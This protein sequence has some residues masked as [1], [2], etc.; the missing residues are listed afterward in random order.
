[1]AAAPGASNVAVTTSGGTSNAM[2]FTVTAVPGISSLS[3][4]TAT[5][6]T[7]VTISGSNL[8]DTQGSGTVW[9]G[10][11]PA[12]VV[13]WSNTQ[14][15]ATVAA[16]AQSGYAR[17]LQNGRWSQPVTF[18]VLTPTITGVTPNPAAPGNSVTIS[19]SGFG[20]LQGNGQVWLG[21]AAAATVTSWNDAQIVA[22]V[23]ANAQS[24][25]AQVLQNGVMSNAVDFTVNIP[26]ITGIDPVKGVA[27]ASVTFTGSGFGA[28]GSVTLGSMAGQVQSWSDTQVVAQ[29]ASGSVSG[30]A[31]IQR[32]DGLQSN[33]LGFTVP[34]A[35]GNTLMPSLLNMAVG[36][37]R[38]LQALGGGG[39]TVT[40]LAWST[41]DATV[42]SLSTDDPPLLTA[43]APGHVTIQAGSASAD[44][45]VWAGVLPV[46][47]ATWSNP[48]NDS[49]VA[50][51]IPA[52]PSATGVA[53]VFAFMNDGTVQ[54]ITSDGKVAWTALAPRG[55]GLLDFQGGLVVEQWDAAGPMITRL[56]GTT[57]VASPGYR[58]GSLSYSAVH[59]DG[60][61]ILLDQPSVVGVNL[62]TGEEKFRVTVETGNSPSYATLMDGLIIAGD[63]YAYVPYSWVEDTGYTPG[64]GCCIVTHFMILRVDSS[65]A[66]D[67]I[68]VKEYSTHGPWPV[69]VGADMITNADQGIVFI[70]QADTNPDDEVVRMPGPSPDG[71][72]PRSANRARGMQPRLMAD[73]E[74]GMGVTTGASVTSFASAP[75]G[76][77]GETITPVLQAQDGSFF[78]TS[79]MYVDGNYWSFMES[80]D[81]GGN[82]RWVVP[83]ETPQIATADG[84]V[85]GASGITY[86]ANGMATGSVGSLPTYS[87]IGNWYRDGDVQQIA[88]PPAA[89]AFSYAAVQG[90]NP[91]GNGAAVR[92]LSAPQLALYA[93]AAANLTATPQ[94]SALLTQFANIARIPEATLAAQLQATARG[95]RDFVFDGP[96]SNAPL[97]P[98]KFPGAASPGVT[99]V[100]EWFG[101][102]DV[103]PY[104]AEGFSQF[105]EYAVWFRLN[106]WQSWIKGW[107]SGFLITST[108]KVNYYAMGT[109]MHEVLHKQ[110]VGGGF[111]HNKPPDARDMGAAISAVGWPSGMVPDH[112]PLSEAFGLLCF[113]GLK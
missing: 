47:T 77:G 91:S 97:D 5:G 69:P 108:G 46:G 32:S 105:N 104:Y 70:Y 72:R 2:P 87:W 89:F 102:Y 75:M 111:T 62:S 71:R 40:G 21:T 52:V 15:A 78:G 98:A 107:F 83:N 22:T 29:V 67:K 50:N 73:M 37:T 64:G 53:D 80:F 106:D 36:D 85:I 112:N 100:G 110:A 25:N 79:S 95:S 59:P 16:N 13:S 4:T 28:A 93:L 96:S 51:L 65:G 23:A 48:G 74:Y 17:V 81:A 99:T 49:G 38:T 56:D 10:T 43:L 66:Y 9:L 109:V 34:T 94:C 61:L 12:T 54:A 19:G 11:A 84:G 55:T 44:V 18:A 41:S 30:I 14:I 60:T 101:L 76:P 7:Q 68:P 31:R 3:R 27:G 90:G 20:A 35:G 42:V 39:Q 82:V 113:P 6:G 1:M 45:T 88:L 33:A 57:G 58:Q 8:G 103:S 86:D 63:G 26:Q 92:P 24:G